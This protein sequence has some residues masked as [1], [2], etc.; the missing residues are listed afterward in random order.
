M[1]RVILEIAMVMKLGDGETIVIKSN[2]FEDNN[3]SL[4]TANVVKMTPHT[5]QNC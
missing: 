3:E 5:K 1:L 2:V 4:T